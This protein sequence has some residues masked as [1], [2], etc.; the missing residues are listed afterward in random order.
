M[1][2]ALQNWNKFPGF[3]Q[4]MKM[5]RKHDPETQERGFG[6]LRPHAG[7]YIGELIAEY[8]SELVTEFKEGKEFG[9]RFWLLDLIGEAK[10]PKAFPFLVECLRGDDENLW[11]WAIVW[12]KELNTKEARR[13][14]WE[15]KSYIKATEEQTAHFP[16][17]SGGRPKENTLATRN[18]SRM[19]GFCCY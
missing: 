1:K 11:Y 13:V 5:I 18:L 7:D 15:A 10:S 14:L 3:K 12:L 4:C 17:L 9:L 16:K 19:N 2:K 8:R 6:L